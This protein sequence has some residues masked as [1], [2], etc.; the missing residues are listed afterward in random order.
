MTTNEAIAH[1]KLDSESPISKEYL[2]L[3]GTKQFDFLFF[4]IQF[5]DQKR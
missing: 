2:Y 3:A 4:L 1:F 5:Y